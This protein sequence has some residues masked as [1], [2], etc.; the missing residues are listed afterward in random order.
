L[1]IARTLFSKQWIIS[2]ILVL[3]AAAVMARLGIWQLNRHNA[4]QLFNESVFEQQALDPLILTAD[5]SE[6]SLINIEYRKVSVRGEYMPS[7]EIILRNQNFESQVGY[8]LFT[9]LIIEGSGETI[10]VQRGW[11]PQENSSV[12]NREIYQ[13]NGIIELSGI[14]RT[15]ETDFGLRLIP[16][17]TLA[18][19][20]A[21]LDV[22]N[23]LDF[24]RLSE[25]IESPL[26]SM[27]LQI[28]PEEGDSG[29]PR[30]L[31]LQLNLTDGPHLGYAGQWFL[32]A[33]VLLLGYPIYLKRQIDLNTEA[34]IEQ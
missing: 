19:G 18:V 10:L 14:L 22:W 6:N 11:I 7:D 23:N 31:P 3:I 4:R 20:E 12:E 16:D 32:F 25:Q 17:P 27:Y 5:I 13:Q 28:Q 8:Q 1:K 34:E 2:T 9:P 26:L 33:A 24:E 29:Y 30:P 15:P 21:R